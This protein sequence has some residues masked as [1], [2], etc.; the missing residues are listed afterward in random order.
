MFSNIRWPRES[1][2]LGWRD[3]L[4]GGPKWSKCLWREANRIPT[5]KPLEMALREPFSSK[6]VLSVLLARHSAG[7]VGV[8]A[9]LPQVLG[10]TKALDEGPRSG[11]KRAV[12]LRERSA[13]TLV[14]Q[15][16]ATSNR[17]SLATA[18]TTQKNHCDSKNT[19]NAA[20]SLRFLREK[21]ATSKLRLAIASDL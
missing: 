6:D 13:I 1:R 10:D 15:I 17:K 11:P 20:I 5:I 14:T 4:F 8:S 21:L 12:H 18:I 3:P 16:A 7:P 9:H 2:P 19:C